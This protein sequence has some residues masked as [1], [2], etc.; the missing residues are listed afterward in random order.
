MEEG[1]GAKG[2]R[3][4]DLPGGSLILSLTYTTCGNSP[5]LS[6]LERNESLS[7]F[8]SSFPR[9][10]LSPLLEKGQTHKHRARPADHLRR[11]C[12]GYRGDPEVC[13]RKKLEGK[14]I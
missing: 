3:V 4:G 14:G 9:H 2:V 10:S 5:L 1:L 6:P 13:P 7:L 12:R 11:I 8:F